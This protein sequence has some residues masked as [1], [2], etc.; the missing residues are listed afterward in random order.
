MAGAS[1]TN[2]KDLLRVYS[3]GAGA[4]LSW[5]VGGESFLRI[6]LVQGADEL[7]CANVTAIAEAVFDQVHGG[8]VAG[9]VARF[10]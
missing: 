8:A 2:V 5:N 7:G 1:V 3:N 4:T 6:S 9:T 10:A